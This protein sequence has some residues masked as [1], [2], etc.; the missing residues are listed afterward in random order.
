[1]SVISSRNR[2]AGDLPSQ[3]RYK[4][5]DPI[6]EKYSLAFA[7]IPKTDPIFSTSNNKL[8]ISI[9]GT[10]STISFSTNTHT[11][12]ELI[13]DFQTK[14]NAVSNVFTVTQHASNDKLS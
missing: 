1:M 9:G 8:V 10:S 13:S 6:Q 4:L 2:I 14:L 7:P 11:M 3:F 5:K 12:I